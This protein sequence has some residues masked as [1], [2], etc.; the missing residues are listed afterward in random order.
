VIPRHHEEQ[1]SES[2]LGA[3]LKT[4]LPQLAE[5]LLGG[6]G[7]SLGVA[8]Q[9]LTEALDPGLVPPNQLGERLL[10]TRRDQAH[11]VVVAG[12]GRSRRVGANQSKAGGA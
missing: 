11:Q 5:D 12:T 1:L 9:E 6:I 3:V 2:V 10:L 8:Q 4:A 7:G